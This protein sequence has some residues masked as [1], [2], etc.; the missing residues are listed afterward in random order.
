[1]GWNQSELGWSVLSR[2]NESYE[3]NQRTCAGV[4]APVPG[5]YVGPGLERPL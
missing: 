3:P 5:M 1:M 4:L 2:T